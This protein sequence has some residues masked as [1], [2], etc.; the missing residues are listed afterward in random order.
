MCQ[1]FKCSTIRCYVPR[2]KLFC[3]SGKK[4]FRRV[5]QLPQLLAQIIKTAGE[6]GSVLVALCCINGTAKR[7]LA[8][9]PVRWTKAGRSNNAF[10]TFPR[11]RGQVHVKSIIRKVSSVQLVSP[12][13]R[14]TLLEIDAEDVLIFLVLP[15]SQATNRSVALQMTTYSR[16]PPFSQLH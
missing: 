4:G 2:I 11:A 14:H 10:I 16:P 6:R 3:F 5:L 15:F 7:L 13:A 1:H 8:D 9:A 12:H